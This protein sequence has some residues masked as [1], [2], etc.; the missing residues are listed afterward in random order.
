MQLQ[1]LNAEK[2]GGL[3]RGCQALSVRSNRMSSRICLS[4]PLARAI[5]GYQTAAWNMPR[6]RSA[7][8]R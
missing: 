3:L 6:F 2:Y 7:R 5:C 1:S 8:C 4:R